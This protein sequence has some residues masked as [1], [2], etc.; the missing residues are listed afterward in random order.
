MFSIDKELNNITDE[1]YKNTLLVKLR[2]LDEKCFTQCGIHIRDDS[3][4]IWSFVTNK[5]PKIWDEQRVFSELCITRFLHQYTAYSEQFH[6]LKTKFI[7]KLNSTTKYPH[8]PY[9]PLIIRK[10]IIP[11]M[12]LQT[13]KQH[14]ADF[15]DMVQ[16]PWQTTLNDK[17]VSCYPH[18]EQSCREMNHSDDAK[19]VYNPVSC[20]QVVV[21]PKKNFMS[22]RNRF[23]RSSE[24]FTVLG[25]YQRQT[26]EEP[27]SSPDDSTYEESEYEE[28][29]ENNA[30]DTTI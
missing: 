17:H 9:D 15:D 3:R 6:V 20:Q 7:S 27:Y 28:F 2:A 23:N 21:Y 13:L 26:E 24:L 29:S 8:I 14:S 10:C 16:W 25:E 18:T 11:I 12:K 4:L 5:L 19:Y 1:N 30:T 22:R